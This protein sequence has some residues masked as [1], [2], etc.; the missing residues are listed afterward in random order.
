MVVE[1]GCYPGKDTG[2]E[3]TSV[4]PVHS[5]CPFPGSTHLRWSTKVSQYQKGGWWWWWL[6]R[7]RNTYDY[8]RLSLEIAYVIPNCHTH[9]L[10]MQKGASR[11]HPPAIPIPFMQRA[12]RAHT[13]PLPYHTLFGTGALRAPIPIPYISVGASRPH[14]PPSKPP[15]HLQPARFARCTPI[16]YP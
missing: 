4:R 2:Y 6:H 9:T 14:T 15:T 3:Q 11:P 7:S 5:R 8:I 12:L 16:P 1:G 13:P 10:Y